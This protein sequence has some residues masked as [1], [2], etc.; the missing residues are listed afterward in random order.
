MIPMRLAGIVKKYDQHGG[1][2]VDSQYLANAFDNTGK[3]YQ[4]KTM[5]KLFSAKQRFFASMN[6]VISAQLGS[7]TSGKL[8]IDTEIYRWDLMNAQEKYAR[9]I[10]NIESSNTAAGINYTTFRIKLDVPY[11][12]EP[13]VLMG[14]DNEYAL[15][16]VGEGQPD[17]AGTIY[18][19]RLQGDN[20]TQFFPQYL[21][22]SGRQFAK[23]WTSVQSE[24]NTVYGTQQYS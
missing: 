7:Q 17:G 9:V 13:D 1:N 10:E 16:I 12:R 6:K 2:F 15:E 8:E 14:E 20:A 21:M 23:V 18:T 19:V 24:Y 3:P 22:E 11:Y 5:M 4:F